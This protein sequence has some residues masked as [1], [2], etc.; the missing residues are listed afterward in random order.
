MY[1]D[2]IIIFIYYVLFIYNFDIYYV[3]FIYF[4]YSFDVGV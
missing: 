4:I 1:K 2:F 3:I